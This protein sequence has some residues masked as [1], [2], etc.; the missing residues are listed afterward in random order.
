MARLK[1]LNG[2]RQM[3]L[4]SL[5]DMAGLPR[6][7]QLV[8]L[9]EQFPNAAEEYIKTLWGTWRSECKKNGSLIEVYSVK[10]LKNGKRVKPYLKTEWVFNPDDD[11]PVTPEQ[12]KFEYAINLKVKIALAQEL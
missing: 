9:R 11:A 6:A 3:A 1:N 10:E 4:R 8:K 2:T 12:A 5:D 7:E